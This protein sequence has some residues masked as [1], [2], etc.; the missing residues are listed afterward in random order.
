MAR[1]TVPV[2]HSVV[3]WAIRESGYD[4]DALAKK[5]HISADTL[6]GWMK[7]TQPRLTQLRALAEKIKRPLATFLL[8][9]PPATVAPAVEF[10]S[11]PGA[12]R[13]QLNPTE[14]RYLREAARL[15][16]FL[17]WI[18]REVEEKPADL[19]KERTQ[20]GAETVAKRMR[21]LVGIKVKEQLEW[22]SASAAFAAWR[23]RLEER[24]VLVLVLSMGKESCRGFS[25]W[26]DYVPLIAVNT[27]G[28]QPEARTFTLFHEYGHLATRTNSACLQGRLRL[29]SIAADSP[30]RWGEEFAAAFLMPADDVHRIVKQLGELPPDVL[31][32][33]VAGHFSVSRAAAALRLVELGYLTWKDYEE[34]PRGEGR[35][36]GG[37]KGRDRAQLRIDQYGSRATELVGR[38]LE[39]ELIGRSEVL[40]YFDVPEP[41][42]ERLIGSSS[43]NE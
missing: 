38:G 35:K 18:A 32:K 40:D 29:T 37:G 36:G 2:T 41:S 25:L 43:D 39:R 42:I 23:Q 8:P 6:R 33:A 7:D 30:E 5:L 10:R 1:P 22:P 9:K 11:P 17:S 28:W 15:Q 16:R 14:R 12:E 19:P 26:E 34:L 4:I 31:S 27:T 24:G 13:R 3:Q 20:V 21:E